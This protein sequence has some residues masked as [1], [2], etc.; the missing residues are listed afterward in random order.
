MGKTQEQIATDVMNSSTLDGD[1]AGFF[2]ALAER[3]YC[4][5]YADIPAA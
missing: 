3:A 1:N 5:Q 2:V 4:P